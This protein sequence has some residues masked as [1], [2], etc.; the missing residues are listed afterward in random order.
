MSEYPTNYTIS[1]KNSITDISKQEWN[2]LALHQSSPFLEWDWLRLLEES[3]SATPSTGWIPQHL[4]IWKDAK[5]LAAAPLYIKRHSAGEFVFDNIW[6]EAAYKLGIPYYPKMLGMAPFTPAGHYRFLIAPGEDEYS[7]TSLLSKRIQG[8]FY[9]RGIAGCNFH[10]ASPAWKEIM[11]EQGFK[12]W[13]HQGFGWNNKGFKTFE[14]FLA[15]FSSNQRRNIKRERKAMHK[16][17]IVFRFREAEEIDHEL[18]ETMYQLYLRTNAKYAPWNCLFLTREFF[19]GLASD[20]DQR[21]L[22]LTATYEHSPENILAMAMFVY[23]DDQLFGRYWGSFSSIDFLHFNVCYYQ[24]I[25]WAIQSGINFFDPGIGAEHKLR[26]G[27]T[28]R[29]FYSLHK[30]FHPDLQS[31]FSNYIEAINML[32]NNQIQALNL[33]APFTEN[34]QD[35]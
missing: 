1:W 16:Q 26:R 11:L 15:L 31:L 19:H 18:M 30:F 24:P 10:F 21:I 14:D 12:S 33:Q 2:Q 4:T 3:G 29:R 34:S 6:A 13:T 23:K 27:F 8:F 25:E 32:T 35:R 17:G 22:L 7:L 28:A 9:I 5:L 20:F